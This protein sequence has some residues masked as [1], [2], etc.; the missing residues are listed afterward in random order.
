MSF[1]AIGIGGVVEH[2]GAGLVEIA[3]TFETQD[4]FIDETGPF[5]EVYES[6]STDDCDQQ[7][8][9]RA[10]CRIKFNQVY[11]ELPSVNGR[12]TPRL[13]S[14]VEVTQESDQG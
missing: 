13:A 5:E 10:V 3:K 14:A 2:V 8:Y 11:F 6:H 9:H 1:G 4:E 12:V 7:T